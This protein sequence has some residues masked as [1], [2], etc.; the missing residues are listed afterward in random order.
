MVSQFFLI[1]IVYAINI[2]T[3]QKLCT[4]GQHSDF[5]Y[6]LISLQD[7][8]LPPHHWKEPQWKCWVC[9][10]KPRHQQPICHSQNRHSK[11]V[12]ALLYVISPTLFL[13]GTLIKSYI[14]YSVSVC[15]QSN[16]KC[17]LKIFKTIFDFFGMY[18]LHVHV[19]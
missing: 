10:N 13:Q 12:S 16:S 8:S 3:K 4:I 2:W 19:Q 17:I 7:L 5:W 11:Q 14:C 9:S 1:G 6:I 15:T 18:V